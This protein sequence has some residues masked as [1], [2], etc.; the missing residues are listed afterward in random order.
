ME[1]AAEDEHLGIGSFCLAGK[2]GSTGGRQGSWGG[3]TTPVHHDEAEMLPQSQGSAKDD[4]RMN[5][6]HGICYSQVGLV[7]ILNQIRRKELAKLPLT[8]IKPLPTPRQTHLV[9]SDGQHHP[10]LRI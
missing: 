4:R 10:Q 9:I 7:D 5:T 1:L 2:R 6:W 3:C 8:A